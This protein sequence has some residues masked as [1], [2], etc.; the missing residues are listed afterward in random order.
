MAAGVESVAQRLVSNRAAC[1]VENARSAAAAGCAARPWRWLASRES[2]V[3][4]GGRRAGRSGSAPVSLREQA[5]Q[6]PPSARGLCMERHP[7][8][9]A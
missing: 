6:H 4:L 7:A 8:L 2:S 1:A 9:S 5:A 3:L